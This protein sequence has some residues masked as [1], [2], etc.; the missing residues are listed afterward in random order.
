[1]IRKALLI[2][3]IV[4]TLALTVNLPLMGGTIPVKGPPSPGHARPPLHINLTPSVS[5]S[6]SPSQIRH[7][8]GFD[9]LTANGANQKIA[10][11]DAYGNNA[12]QGDLNTFCTQFGLSSATVQILGNNTG[13][14]TGWALETALDVEWAHAIAPAA[15]II[16]SVANSSS[17]GDLLN[18]VDAAVNAGATIV[19]MSWGG[20]EFSGMSVYDNHFNRPNVTFTASSGD[21]GAGV[22]WPAVS[23]YVLGVGGTTLYLDSNGN[24]SSETA[25]TGSGGGVSSVYSEPSYQTGWQTANRRGV[26]DVSFLADP[27]T[28][29]FVY[30]S[31]NG[32]WFVV[33]GTSASAPQWAALVALANQLRVNSGSTPVSSLNDSLYSLAQGS[34]T[35]P[36]T[37]NPA[38]FYDVSQGN[39]GG[40]LATA[41]YDFVTGLG[42]PVANALVPALAP[43][44]QNPNFSISATPASQTT[45]AGASAGYTVSLT[46]IGG[47]S[48][49]V[50]LTIAG[51]PS[52]ATALFTPQSPAAP[53]AS[54]LTISTGASTQPGSYTLTI[55]GQSGGLIHTATATLI[56]QAPAGAGF[57]IGVSPAVNNLKAGNSAS[58][59]VTITGTGGFSGNVSLAVSGL[60]S[61]ATASFS[62]VSISGSGTSALSITT[63][64]STPRGTYQVTVTGT[65]GSLAHSAGVSLRVR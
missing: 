14:D 35:T 7:A 2:N 55:T 63:L 39:N 40:Y 38:Y 51:L 8:Y 29:V 1:M 36:Y 41:Q 49:A 52:A 42:S 11:V 21:G 18:A 20:S 65:S 3:W 33:G 60:P 17:L 32:G 13:I 22:E 47:F 53:G 19:S 28:G 50:S 54:T 10:L 26:P 31:V 46:S 37:V 45:T 43:S 24:R 58:D 23:P 30:D 61:G 62:P 4:P 59:T 6:Y 34:T 64:R 9:Q 48:S 57:S 27:N 16:L 5:T 15:T 12:I 25:W 56:V 44:T